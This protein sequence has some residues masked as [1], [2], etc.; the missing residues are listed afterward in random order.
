[1]SADQVYFISDAI[2][3]TATVVVFILFL[4]AAYF[5]FSFEE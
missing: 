1:M 4:C 5:A 3:C 2:V